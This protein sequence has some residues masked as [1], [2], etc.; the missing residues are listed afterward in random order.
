[1]LK[2]QRA[3][4]AKASVEDLQF[5]QVEDTQSLDVLRDDGSGVARDLVCEVHDGGFSGLNSRA[6]V[7]HRD[8]PHCVG[9]IEPVSQDLPVLGGAVR[10]PQGACGGEGGQ[11]VAVQSHIRHDR[12]D[13]LSPGAIDVRPQCQQLEVIGHVAEG[14]N[15]LGV[16]VRRVAGRAVVGHGLD[17]RHEDDARHQTR[18]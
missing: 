11:L 8:A 7:I 15:V 2:K 1:V 9:V 13:Q 6:P 16:K 12:F 17:E 10:R 4:A 3:A 18:G 5:G 14:G